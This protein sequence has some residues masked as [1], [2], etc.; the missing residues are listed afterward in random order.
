MGGTPVQTPPPGKYEWLVV[1]PDK[2]GQQQKRLEVR[3]Q[4]FAGLKNYIESGQFKT[5]GAILNSKPESD[6]D[7]TKFDFYGSTIIVVAES[8]EE[9]VGIL[10]KDIYATSGVWDVEKAQIWPAKI[11]F[12]DP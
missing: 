5:G 9:V 4:H 12:R 11:A 10:E 3:S 6:D 2:P 8:R 7:P 1:V